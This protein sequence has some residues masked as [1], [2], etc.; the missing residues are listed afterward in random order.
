MAVVEIRPFRA[1]EWRLYRRLR[2][3][4]L[5]DSP[6]AFASTLDAARA[7][8][9]GWWE[10]RLAGLDDELDLALLAEADGEPAG[11]A[12]G[13]IEPHA[14]HTAAVYQMW[15]APEH[16]RSGAGRRLLEGV[17][18]WAKQRGVNSICLEVTIGNDPARHLYEAAGFRASGA[19][20]PLRP[21]SPLEEQPMR[22]DVGVPVDPAA[23]S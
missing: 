23:A 20:V 4:A 9:V 5:A 11:L 7:R 18:D 8:P 14:R 1:D 15:V 16:R 2:L 19:P 17:I 21:G 6:D 3:R 12:W 13:R 22:L 10:S